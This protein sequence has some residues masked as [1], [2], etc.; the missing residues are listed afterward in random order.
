M[1][2]VEYISSCVWHAP[3][4][5]WP[6]YKPFPVLLCL[7]EIC[8]V[9]PTSSVDPLLPWSFH[10]GLDH[11]EIISNLRAGGKEEFRTFVSLVPALLESSWSVTV[12]PTPNDS[13]SRLTWPFALFLALLISGWCVFP[14]LSVYQPHTLAFILLDAPLKFPLFLPESMCS[15]WCRKNSISLLF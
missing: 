15:H 8:L 2:D 6:C 1:R 11:I 9:W 12:S 5:Y 13:C 7:L 4:S 10:L 14:A 3:F